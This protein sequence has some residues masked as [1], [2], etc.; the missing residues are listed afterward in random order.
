VRTQSSCAR[1]DAPSTPGALTPPEV[2]ERAFEGLATEDGDGARP[3]ARGRVG[4]LGQ[5]VVGVCRPVQQ[6]LAMSVQV[7]TPRSETPVVW[8]GSSCIGSVPPSLS[9][10]FE[11]SRVT[12]QPSADEQ[13]GMLALMREYVDIRGSPMLRPRSKHLAPDV[14]MAEPMGCPGCGDQSRRSFSHAA[15]RTRSWRKPTMA[16]TGGVRRLWAVLGM[17]SRLI[18]LDT[19]HARQRYAKEYEVKLTLGAATWWMR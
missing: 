1:S 2:V 13:R 18:R 12:Q 17:R 6:R 11:S 10:A 9:I 15:T 4:S 16:S 19:D 7:F 5:Q 8:T 14:R 3:S